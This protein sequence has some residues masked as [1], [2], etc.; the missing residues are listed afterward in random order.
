MKILICDDHKIVRDGLRQ[1]ILPLQDLTSV[2]EA[3]TG[4]EALKLMK[5][6]EYDVLLLD[7]SLPDMSGMEVLQM[8]KTKWAST[9]VLMLSMRPHEQYAM[10]A[11]KLG[12]SGYLTKEATS[13]EL[14]KA[15]SVVA[16]GGKYVSEALVDNIAGN[17]SNNTTEYL[18][19]TLSAR[20]FEILLQIANG[21][22]LQDI[23]TELF[24][25]SKTVTTYRS[26]ILS[27]MEMTSNSE[28]VK[29]CVE[30]K[31]I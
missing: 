28:L 24:I 14:L 5:Q 1:L 20:E 13:E 12:A 18:H 17:I 29:Y 22:S 6:E 19:D 11:H 8:V 9:N 30:N 10:R 15:L 25:S 27:K 4:A 2:A 23:G 3:G 16:R 21:M 31:L 7:I 26:R